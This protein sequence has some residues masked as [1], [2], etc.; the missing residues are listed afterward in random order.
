MDYN[1][2]HVFLYL[3]SFYLLNTYNLYIYYNSMI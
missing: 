1:I 3:N 2:I